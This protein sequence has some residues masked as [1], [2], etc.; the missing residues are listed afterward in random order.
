MI[1]QQLIN[2]INLEADELL[3]SDK[4][5][6]PYVNQAIDFLSFFLAGIKD[7]S[8]MATVDISDG[9][10]VPAL[11]IDFVPANGYP[12]A[13]N[14]DRFDVMVD[15]MTIRDV[16][17]T[18]GKP[19]VAAMDDNIPFNDMYAGCLVLITSYMIKKKTYIPVEYCAQDKSFVSELMAAI[20][21]AKGG[22]A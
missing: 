6:I 11:F 15:D 20:K 9:D 18:L 16:H 10:S 19:H 1:T 12:I 4:D 2:L 14:G 13:I 22:A 5:N 3:D 21:A 8:V 7:P 17:M